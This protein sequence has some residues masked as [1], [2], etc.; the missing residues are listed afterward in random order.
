MS[1]VR[2][3][4]EIKCGED[5]QSGTCVEKNQQ[6]LCRADRT[7]KSMHVD[8]DSDFGYLN[9]GFSSGQQSNKSD[10]SFEVRTLS[11]AGIIWYEGSWKEKR[12]GDFLAVFLV[13]GVLHLAINLG[14]DGQL[15]AVSTNRTISD[16]RWHSV[17]LTRKERRVE[18]T[19][20]GKRVITVVTSPGSTFLDTNGLVYLGGRNAAKVRQLAR[21]GLTQ[22]FVG[23][24]RN[25]EIHSKRINPFTDT[26][27]DKTPQNCIH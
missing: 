14:N 27:S 13:E 25:I 6:K 3:A 10:F 18:V 1:D 8:E 9:R 16:D 23:C 17:Q 12:D 20:D 7:Y 5:C 22:K 2:L 24:I 26:I 21:L 11:R 19:V 15:K 4:E